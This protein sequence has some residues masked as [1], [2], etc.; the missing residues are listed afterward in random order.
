MKQGKGVLKFDDNSKYEGTFLNDQPD[1]YGVFE[2]SLL[3]YRGH[4]QFGCFEG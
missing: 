1:G 2:N 3:V 4:F